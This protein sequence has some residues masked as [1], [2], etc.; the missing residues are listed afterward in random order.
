MA[1]FNVVMALST[2]QGFHLN[3]TGSPACGGSCGGTRGGSQPRFLDLSCAANSDRRCYPTNTCI[4]PRIM[5]VPQQLRIQHALSGAYLGSD[6][7][8]L[9]ADANEVLTSWHRQLFRKID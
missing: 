2:N 4:V 9:P 1:D 7:D 8:K 6:T 5:V 3:F